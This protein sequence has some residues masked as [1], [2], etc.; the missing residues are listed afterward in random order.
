MGGF[1][2][3]DMTV[4]H[5]ILYMEK[6]DYL[7]MIIQEING[8]GVVPYQKGLSREEINTTP[9][10]DAGEEFITVPHHPKIVL[11]SGNLVQKYPIG[12]RRLIEKLVEVADSLPDGLQLGILEIYRPASI[13]QQKRMKKY[14]KLKN[15][16]PEKTDEEIWK[17]VDTFIARP[18][19]PHQTGG[20][21]DLT[22][23]W[24]QTG[25]PFDMGVPYA[26]PGTA[27]YTNSNLVSWEAQVHRYLLW[28]HMTAV[29]FRNYHA[30]WWHYEYGTQRW[31]KHLKIDNA[32]YP[33]IMDE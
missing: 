1:F 6:R 18:G 31:A 32:Y 9:I 11:L 10:I 26:T 33:A 19:G 3:S 28:A 22:L 30:E 5:S 8:T 24:A 16:Y 15:N 13:Q 25:K 12:R 29:G 27:S 7:Q 20:A 14:H 4:V 21:I 2:V 23:V 17:I